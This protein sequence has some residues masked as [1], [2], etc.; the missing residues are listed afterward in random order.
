LSGVEETR[1]DAETAGGDSAVGFGFFGFLPRLFSLAGGTFIPKPLLPNRLVMKL[2]EVLEGITLLI[3]V[4]K[5]A[6]SPSL[7]S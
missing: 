3:T 1:D 6:Y 2:R 4:R 5:P 7:N